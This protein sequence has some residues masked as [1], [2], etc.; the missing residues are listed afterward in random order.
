MNIFGGPIRES[1]KKEGFFYAFFLGTILSAVFLILSFFLPNLISSNYYQKSLSQL[2]SQA[3]T[4]KNEFSNRIS[5]IGH[6]QKI[7]L[8]APFP[9]EED[10]IF[11]LFKELDLRKE[12]EGISYFNSSY[13]AFKRV[14]SNDYFHLIFTF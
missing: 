8:D 11:N 13:T 14:W 12:L 10:E 2:R 4:I 6:K 5:E 3:K 7:I 9:E 1:I